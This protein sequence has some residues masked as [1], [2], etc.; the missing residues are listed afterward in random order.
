MELRQLRYLVAIAEEGG[1][2]R[3]AERVRVAQPAVSQQIAQLERELGARLF[4]RS[5]RRV[6]LTAAGEAFLPC[7][8]ATL[9]AAD[10][11][12]DAVAAL[13]GELAG[14]LTLG[15]I[16]CPPDSFIRQLGVYRRRHPKVRLT[17]RTGDPEALAADVASGALA[18]ALIGVTADRLPAGP[19]GQRL[20]ATLA[21]ADLGT[22]PLVLAVPPDHHLAEAGEASLPDLRHEPIVTLTPGTG[23]RSV[24]ESACATAGFTPNVHAETDDLAVLA[25][26]VAHG[27]GV[28]VLPRSAARSRQELVTLPLHDAPHRSMTLIWNRDRTSA[29]TQAF[30]QDHT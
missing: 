13:R 28:G 6:R 19:A 15:T 21:S 4:D 1:F 3:A 29:L 10:A 8:R 22:E 18:A 26:M 16:P 11:G 24:L 9:A 25:D 12:K 20:R 5:G 17:L 30:L 7:A 27:L 23:L 14:Q 2:T